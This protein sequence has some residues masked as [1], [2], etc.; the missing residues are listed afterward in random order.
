MTT[1]RV[2]VAAPNPLAAAAGARLAASGG[3]AIDAALAA[4]MVAMVTEVGVVSPA[5]GGYVTVQPADGVVPVT[6]DGGVEMPGRGMPADRFG[7]GTFDVTTGYG[8]GITMTVGH[9]SVATPGTM[10]AVDAAHRRYGRAPWSELMAPAVEVAKHGF[11]LGQAS[12]H[13]LEFVHDSVYGTEPASRSVLHDEAGELLAQGATVVI[14]DL[15]ESLAAIA[16]DGVETFYAGDLARAI[17][18]E[19]TDHEGLLTTADL[20]AYQPVL[21]PALRVRLGEWLLGTNPPPAVGGVTLAAMLT[22]LG[23]RPRGAWTTDDLA[24]L[25]EVEEAVLSYRARELDLAPDRVAAA[26]AFLALVHEGDLAALGSPSTVNVSAVS[27]DGAGCTITVSSGYGSGIIAEGTGIWLNNCLGEQ[28]LNRGGLHVLPPGQRLI[29]NMAPTVAHR[30]DGS[31]IAAGSPGAD[32]IS[33]ALL[34]ALAAFAN[35]GLSLDEAIAHPRLH[36]RLT[37]PGPTVDHEDGLRLTGATTLPTQAFAGQ[38]MY[39][40]GVSAALWTPTDGLSAAS[41]PRRDGAVAI[42]A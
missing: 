17:A 10:A 21:R 25:V 42:S 39:F 8:G 30:D 11:P 37:G 41:D 34:M 3:N 12:R 7:R 24:L 19:V 35:G 16:A 15:S 40:G 20:A 38:S 1:N 31:V 29:S 2:A 22:L 27:D 23:G 9:G 18:A 32:R 26:E 14:P 13:Y 28:E 5:S 33:T 36:V 4:C 6:I